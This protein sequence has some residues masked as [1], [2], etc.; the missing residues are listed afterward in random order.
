MKIEI[1]VCE[2]V[3]FFIGHY[4][5]KQPRNANSALCKLDAKEYLYAFE[6]EATFKLQRRIDT[7]LH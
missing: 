4:N 1:P 3:N 6:A 2:T 5:A 7:P